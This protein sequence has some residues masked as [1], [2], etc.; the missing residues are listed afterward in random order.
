MRVVALI[1]MLIAVTQAFQLSHNITA[2]VVAGVH[3]RERI[4]THIATM[5]QSRAR[6]FKGPG[7]LIVVPRLVEPSNSCWRGNSGNVD[8]NRNFPANWRLGSP[9]SKFLDFGGT[10]PLSEPESQML[11]GLL[12]KH[13]PDVVID[14]HSGETAVYTPWH[15]QFHAPDLALTAPELVEAVPRLEGVKAGPGGLYGGYLAYGTI[16]DTAVEYF[17]AKCVFTFEVYGDQDTIDC[18]RAFNPP[19]AE[20]HELAEHWNAVIDE[21]LAVCAE[22]IRHPR[23]PA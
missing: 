6:T 11:W 22:R 20:W 9:D 18:K 14:L 7:T 23:S 1:L 3:A 2:L 12:D 16:A 21:T 10:Q 19:I 8:I 15:S 13:R 4:T 17:G 5:L